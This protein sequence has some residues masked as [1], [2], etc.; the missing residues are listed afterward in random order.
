MIVKAAIS[1]ESDT[2]TAVV[3]VCSAVG[4]ID[5]DLIVL[6][7]SHHH[8]PDFEDL[9]DGV[10]SRTNPRNLIG[11]TGESII[12]PDREVE[13][14]PAVALWAAK[15]PG[16]RVLPFMVD[17]EDLG[18]LREEADWHERV[19]V[20]PEAA[21]SFVV[22]PDPF[23]IDAESCL[24]RLNRAFSDAA[25]VGG[26]ASGAEAPGQNRLFLN[27]QVLRQGLVGVSLSGPVAITAVVSQGCRPIGELLKVTKAQDN[28]ILELRGQP[29][30]DILRT[31]YESAPPADRALIQQQGLQV[32]CMLGGQDASAD[33]KEVLIRSLIGVVEN[34]GLAVNTLIRTGQ[35]IQ[36][37]VRDAQAAHAD[38]HDVLAE[39]IAAM[40]K[41]P[42][43]GLLFSCNGRGRRMFGVPH[44]DINM[45]NSIAGNC[46]VAGFFAGGEI[47]PVG[48]RTYIHG[49]TSSLVLFRD[50]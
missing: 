1:T 47:G 45:V 28:V 12:G 20:T 34:K 22:L 30:M 16:V 6:F 32:G 4:G 11:C 36:F 18:G 31:V 35:V 49:F 26:M 25:I 8:G 39:R 42:A 27:D 41:P 43:G 46:P 13:R 9:L 19:G 24:S 21:P 2:N 14:A 29:A 10:R 23:S 48:R 37:H 40:G 5:P 33:R 44:H 7:A 15:M 17:Q 3:E 50:A 38:L